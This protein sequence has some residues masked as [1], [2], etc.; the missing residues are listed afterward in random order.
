[1]LVFIDESGDPGFKVTKGSSGYFVIALIIFEDDLDAEDAAVRI[2]RLKRELKKS[3]RFEFK[4]N[5]GNREVRAAFLNTIR[6]CSFRIRAIVFS[7]T[8]IYSTYLR[9][10][11]ERFYNFA[12]RQVLEHNN[13]TIQNAKIRLDGRGEVAFRRQLTTYLKRSL[14]SRTKRVMTNLRFRD[15]KK[16]VLIQMADMVA[17][18]IRRHYERSTQDWNV[19]RRI[20]KKKEEDVWLFT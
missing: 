10:N 2:K 20:I 13:K 3:E 12:L 9:D 6:L 17:G 18:S 14:N 16:D 19:Y 5:K 1:M 11:K 4:F 15:S 8:T 7:K